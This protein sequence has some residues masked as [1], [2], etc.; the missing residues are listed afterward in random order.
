MII[1]DQLRSELTFHKGGE[2]GRRLQRKF[3]K[4]SKLKTLSRFPQQQVTIKSLDSSDLVGFYFV[5]MIAIR[6]SHGVSGHCGERG[7]K[8]ETS[9]KIKMEE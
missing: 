4:Q 1:D 7:A 3:N 5:G 2:K 8:E 9:E 6:S